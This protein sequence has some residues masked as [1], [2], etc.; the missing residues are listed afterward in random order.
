MRIYN[1][2]T[3]E[4]EKFEPHDPGEVKMYVCGLTVQ[5]YS[6]IGHVRGA[7]NY[8]V[9]R[10]YLEYRDYK[11]RYIQNFTDINE[12]IVDRAEEEGLKPMELANKYAEAY[13]EELLQLNVEMP[14]RFC[15]V[16]DNIS[17]IIEMI[18]VLIEKGYAYE[19]GGDVYFS[20]EEFE[21][22]GKL[23]GREL[24]EM[25]AGARVEVDEKKR[26]P[27]DFA[28]WKQVDQKPRW[29]SPWG[30]GWPGWHIECSVMSLK[31]LDG[32][33]DIHGG[34]T[35]LVFPH[36]ENEIAQAEAYTG[37]EP[38]VKYWVHNGTVDLGGEKMSKSIGNVYQT[39][40][41]ID[42]YS[43]DELRYFILAKH[44][45]SPINFSLEEIDEASR[46]LE[47]LI[48][49]SALLERLL[50][51]LEIGEEGDSLVGEGLEKRLEELQEEFINVMDDDFNTARGIAVLHEMAGEINS[52]TDN[53]GLTVDAET[54][55]IVEKADRIFGELA[56]IFG[57]ELQPGDS[58]GAGDEKFQQLVE[59]L[60]ELREEARQE[61]NYQ[62]ADRIRDDLAEMGIEVADTPRG[63]EWRLA[64]HE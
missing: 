62:L 22:Y 10:R 46:S 37:K 44:Y 9:I 36:H 14:D 59:Y 32:A 24:E 31:Y 43:A 54:R 27:G 8:D 1:S 39:R 11:V 12:K 15:R 29:D 6:H 18:E 49:T 25:Q 55:R 51:K 56:E 21:N 64:E 17:E 63:P 2:L 52:A 5:D 40:E 30:E 34:G 60:L 42:R 58:A 19:V 20:V 33:V 45:R 7:I 41:L 38:F 16:S 23:S 50:E 13:R 47:N 61:E 57:F 48:N 26:H 4:K 3:G 35:D 53:L 28:L